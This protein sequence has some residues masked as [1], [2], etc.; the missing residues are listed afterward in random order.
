MA[1]GPSGVVVCSPAER[2]GPG[3]VWHQPNRVVTAPT[4]GGNLEILHWNLAASRWIRPPE[5]YA[6]CL[7]L[8]ETSEE[9]PAAEEVFRM[10]PASW[11]SARLVSYAPDGAIGHSPWAARRPLASSTSCPSNSRFSR[12]FTQ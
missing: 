9:R 10:L 4:W 8:L 7:L 3:W 6:G 2:P 12:H 1:E 11:I 5:D